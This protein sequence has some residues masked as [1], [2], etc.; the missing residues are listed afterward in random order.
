MGLFD[1]IPTD[2][3]ACLSFVSNSSVFLESSR[4]LTLVLP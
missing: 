1:N 3:T 2:K 4:K